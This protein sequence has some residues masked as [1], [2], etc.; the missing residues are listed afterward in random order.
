[1]ETKEIRQLKAT[2]IGWMIEWSLLEG[3]GPFTPIDLLKAL[4]NAFDYSME[5]EG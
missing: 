1:M 5:V 3:Q 2:V 4:I